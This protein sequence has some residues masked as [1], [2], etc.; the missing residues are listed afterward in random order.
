MVCSTQPYGKEVRY[1]SAPN[2]DP[3]MDGETPMAERARTGLDI[4]RESEIEGG[5][6]PGG[7]RS[8]ARLRKLD[9]GHV[10]R[11]VQFHARRILRR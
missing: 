2:S 1:S 8:A 6:G 11:Q 5:L 7:E 10:H 4:G 9:A 3:A